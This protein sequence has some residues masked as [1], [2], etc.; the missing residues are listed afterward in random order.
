MMWY[1]WG[2]EKEIEGDR[3][4]TEDTDGHG[5]DGGE[6]GKESEKWRKS[7]LQRLEKRE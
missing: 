2:L 5:G 6:N 3:G 4:K 7:W 1:S